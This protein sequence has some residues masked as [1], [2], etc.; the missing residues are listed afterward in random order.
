MVSIHITYSLY[1]SKYKRME[2]VE[3]PKESEKKERKKR[4][5]TL[6]LTVADIGR[7]RNS[8]VKSIRYKPRR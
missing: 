7:I 4:Q 1:S 3:A 2:F 6:E 5:R 8:L